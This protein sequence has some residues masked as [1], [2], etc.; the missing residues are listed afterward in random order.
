MEGIKTKQDAKNIIKLIT[1]SAPEILTLTKFPG[2]FYDFYIDN[3][4]YT[5]KILSYDELFDYFNILF[6]MKYYE[7]TINLFNEIL[8]KTCP[9][10]P[11]HNG[12]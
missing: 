1:N 3:K 12:A 8:E 10:A 2:S 4:E 5:E 9:V 11:R 6:H 7:D